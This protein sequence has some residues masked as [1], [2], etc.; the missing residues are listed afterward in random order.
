MTSYLDS[1]CTPCPAGSYTTIYGTTDSCVNCPVGTTTLPGSAYSNCFYIDILGGQLF[2]F[3]SLYTNE[4]LSAA[5]SH[6]LQQLPST[7]SDPYV[8]FTY[9]SSTMQ[10]YNPATGLCLDDMGHGYASVSSPSD[11]LGFEP[12][13]SGKSQQ[14]GY[15]IFT[16]YILNPNN[17]YDKCLDSNS[18]YPAIYLWSCP[19]GGVNHEWST[20]LS[21]A[22]GEYTINIFT[23]AH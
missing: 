8:L 1:S 19:Y 3:Q 21:C 4:Y 15:T 23:S 20:L 5:N 13:N 10:I 12:C 6:P 7:L 9:N 2:A 22:P 16:Q 17:P 11:T 14:F 18:Q